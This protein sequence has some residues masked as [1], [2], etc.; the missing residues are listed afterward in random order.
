MSKL[1]TPLK[2]D[3]KINHVYRTI[4]LTLFIFATFLSGASL[5]L[6][7]IMHLEPCPLC[8]GQRI[9][10]FGLTL[11]YFFAFFVKRPILFIINAI[12]QGLFFLLGLGMAL[13]QIWLMHHPIV[14]GSGCMPDISILWNYL[15][16]TEI[17]K[18][19]FTGTASCSENSWIW[20]GISLPE[21]SA[22]AFVVLGIGTIATFI[23]SRKR[24]KNQ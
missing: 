20:L 22:L 3:L 1:L 8:I 15:P 2:N 10:V 6:Q 19:F 4:C 24:F 23:I 21:W 7:W 12:F 11:C 5:Y 14:E 18:I 17:V 13:R 9:A 16:V